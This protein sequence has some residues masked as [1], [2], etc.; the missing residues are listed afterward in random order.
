MERKIKYIGILN[1]EKFEIMNKS[2]VKAFIE[3]DFGK[4]MDERVENEK[5]FGY[6]DK[7]KSDDTYFVDVIYNILGRFYKCEKVLRTT[8]KYEY[9]HGAK[10]ITEIR[11]KN[12]K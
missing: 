5:R 7:Y 12:V 1:S 11:Q 10:I 3:N 2:D 8:L 9:G 4:W 6:T